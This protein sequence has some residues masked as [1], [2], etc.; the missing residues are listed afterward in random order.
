MTDHMSSIQRLQLRVV[1]LVPPS[2]AFIDLL[3]G[4]QC[5]SPETWKNKY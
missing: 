4:V 5:T 1:L 2:I 3:N